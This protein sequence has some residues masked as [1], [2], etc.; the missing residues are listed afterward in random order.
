M[1]QELE[2]QQKAKE[3]RCGKCGKAFTSMVR[4]QHH[5]A[6]EHAPKT[7]RDVRTMK[8]IVHS[9]GCRP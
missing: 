9:T 7:L 3:H 6:A 5:R 4:L 8:G 1:S 2:L